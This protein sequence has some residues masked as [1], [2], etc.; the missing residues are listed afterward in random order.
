[1]D[2]DGFCIARSGTAEH[3]LPYCWPQMHAKRVSQKRIAMHRLKQLC[4]LFKKKKKKKKKRRLLWFCGYALRALFAR[5]FSAK[6]STSERQREFERRLLKLCE[7]GQLPAVLDLLHEMDM[8][9]SDHTYLTLLKACIK[10]KALAQ[11]LQIHAHLA[12]HQVPLAGILGDYMVV[13]LAK[14]GAIDEAKQLMGTLAS[15]TIFSWNA[16]I[17]SCV[18]FGR[19]KEALEL[20]QCMRQDGVNPDNLTY[21]SLFKAC[22]NVLDF[23]QGRTI[24]G[25]A[26]ANGFSSDRFICTTLISMY[27]KCGDIAEA[28]NVFTSLSECCVVSCNALLSAYV[29]QGEAE[30]AL[31]FYRQMLDESVSIDEHTFVFTLRACCILAENENVSNTEGQ[32]VKQIPFEIGHALHV[33]AHRKGFIL[34]VHIGTTLLTMYSK[35]GDV[36]LAEYVFSQLVHRN[37]VSWNA[38]LSAFVEHQKGEKALT[39]YRKMHQEGLQPHEL[40]YLM[41]IQACGILAGKSKEAHDSEGSQ[42]M[43]TPLLIG[44]AL[45]DD[46]RRAGFALNA[47]VATAL[48][49]MYGKCGAFVDSEDVFL[50]MQHRDVV[51]WNAMLTVFIEQGNAVKALHLFCQMQKECRTLNQLTFVLAIQACGTLVEDRETIFSKCKPSKDTCLEIG[52]ALHADACKLHFTADSIVCNTLISMYGKCGAIKEAE[53]VR[54]ALSTRNIVTG[55]AM[56]SAYV[57]CGQGD[58][59]LMFYGLLCKEFFRPGFIALVIALQACSLFAEHEPPFVTEGGSAKPVALHIGQALHNDAWEQGFV[60]HPFVGTAL[61]SMYA[62]CGAI[63]EAENLFTAL[64]ERDAV[65]WNALLSAYV[66]QGE[67]IKALQ[68]YRQMQGEGPS[69]SQLTLTMALQ[70]CRLLAEGEDAVSWKGQAVKVRS[71]NLGKA[72]HADAR[73]EGYA[74]GL[75]VGNTLMRMY[76]K[77]RALME[78]EDVFHAIPDCNILSWNVL[79]SACIEQGLGEKAFQIYRQIQKQEVILD[80]VT[81]MCMLQASASSGSLTS[82]EHLHFAILSAGY[83]QVPSLAVTLIHAYGSCA[84]MFDAHA[85]FD[86]LAESNIVSWNAC[87]SGYAGGGSSMTSLQMFS[88]LRDIGLDYFESM[89]KDNTIVPDLKHY[90]SLVDLLGR[91]GDFKRLQSMLKVLPKQANL[92]IWLCLLGACRIHQN[93]EVGEEAF[94]NAVKMQPEDATAYVMMSNGFQ[95]IVDTGQVL[96]SLSWSLRLNLREEMLLCSGLSK[97]MQSTWWIDALKAFMKIRSIQLLNHQEC[98]ELSKHMQSTWWIDALKAFMKI[99]SIPVTKP[100]RMFRSM[101]M[102]SI[103][104]WLNCSKENLVLLKCIKILLHVYGRLCENLELYRSEIKE[105]TVSLQT[106]ATHVDGGASSILSIYCRAFLH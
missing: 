5:L 94:Q 53:H 65:S 27:G 83:D 100:S 12:F 42:T 16:M 41:T 62:K 69:S 90:G 7:N 92:A 3:R 18:D 95:H 66:E 67:G 56:L 68:L 9:A 48:L 36:F 88:G 101:A 19:S 104:L 35:S 6:T 52:Q 17:S 15:R 72:L 51:A 106:M 32:T 84:S 97:H 59:G 71:L 29:D 44:R 60:T 45:H 99:P 49:G 57:D 21:V 78:V 81:L 98:S 46:I 55:N 47:C 13:T 103:L 25:E 40:T 2:N 43:R 37:V 80:D 93:C 34:N 89:M 8:A 31:R 54:G 30:R 24:H 11:A 70:A 63:A 58:K 82:C 91:A 1:M 39:L 74:S 10:H 102:S 77:C 79:L 86:G 20:Y 23:G 76:G 75:V 33:D 38:M 26:R 14:S 96:A 50:S 105:V 61:L 73:K 28:E 22:G 64:S 87:I 85:F 4:T